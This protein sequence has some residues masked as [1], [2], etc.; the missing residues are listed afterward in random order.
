[1]NEIGW[2]DW[3]VFVRFMVRV[4]GGFF[5]TSLP[6]TKHTDNFVGIFNEYFVYITIWNL[7]IGNHPLGF[8]KDEEFLE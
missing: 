2:E 6:P 4:I 7:Y 3:I 5:C 1:L 8:L